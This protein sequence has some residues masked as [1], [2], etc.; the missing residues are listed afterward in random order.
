MAT[1]YQRPGSPYFQASISVG[2]VRRRISTEETNRGKA[3][4]KADAIEEQLNRELENNKGLRFSDAAARFFKVKT[5]KKNTL[6]AYNVCFANIYGVLGDFALPSLED[7]HITHYVNERMKQAVTDPKKSGMSAIRKDLAFLSSLL[8][9]AKHWEPLLGSRNVAKDYDKAGLPKP[10]ERTVWLREDDVQNLIDNC[11]KPYQ[12]LFIMIAVFTG[13][14]R[15]EILN[16]RWDEIDFRNKEI[17]LD[18]LGEQKTKTGQTRII[19]LADALCDTLR[20][21]F[22]QRFS[23]YVF[24]NPKTRRPYTTFKTFW[25]RVRKDAGLENVRIH[26]LRHTFASWARQRGMDE[27]TVMDIL[28]HKTRSMLKRYSHSSRESLHDNVRRMASVTISVT[29]PHHL[30]KSAEGEK[31]KTEG[32]QEVSGAAY[33]TRTRDPI[34][35]NDVLYRL[36]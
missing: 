27:V 4:K 8:T 16:L 26:D 13:M 17:V 6:D 19:P 3:Q 33:V 29:R 10:K 9:T 32:N 2:G 11:N 1:L 14:R 20:V 22:E 34:I 28:G 12:M 30:H 5:L 7:R 18:N 21:T 36:S 35:T 31:A 23:D 25:G 24:F 15:S